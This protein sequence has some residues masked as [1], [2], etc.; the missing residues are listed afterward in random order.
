[1]YTLMTWLGESPYERTAGQP[2]L[3]GIFSEGNPLPGVVALIVQS[4]LETPG[5]DEIVDN[6]TFDLTPENRLLSISIVVRVAGED[7]PVS[8][9]VTP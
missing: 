2:Y 4:V 6:P 9:D 7:I 8:V 3:D 5:V 1:V